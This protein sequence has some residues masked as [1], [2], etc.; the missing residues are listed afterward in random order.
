[1]SEAV[2]EKKKRS[3]W[4]YILIAIAGLITGFLLPKPFLDHKRVNHSEPQITDTIQNH[5]EDSKQVD[6]VSSDNH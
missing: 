4:F 6:S 2:K 1:M 3:K 5:S